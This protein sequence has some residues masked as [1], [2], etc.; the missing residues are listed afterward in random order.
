MQIPSVLIPIWCLI[1]NALHLILRSSHS[2]PSSYR[3]TAAEDR[4][5]LSLRLSAIAM[6]FRETTRVFALTCPHLAADGVASW[7]SQV[8]TKP[9]E[10]KSTDPRKP[11]WF[12]LPTAVMSFRATRRVFALMSRHLAV[13]G[14][15]TSTKAAHV[16]T[17]DLASNPTFQEIALYLSHGLRFFESTQKKK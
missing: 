7:G 8:V 12:R 15:T 4:W 9:R 3:T 10:L 14:A 1:R 13:T 16:M 11:L 5:T 2:K 6:R 17:P